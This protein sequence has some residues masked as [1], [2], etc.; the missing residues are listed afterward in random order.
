MDSDSSVDGIEVDGRL[1]RLK[2]DCCKSRRT[3]NEYDFHPCKLQKCTFSICWPCLQRWKDQSDK[4]V[5]KNFE[6]PQCHTEYDTKLI[7]EHKPLSTSIINKVNAKAKRERK[8]K[9]KMKKQRDAEMEKKR[10]VMAEKQ[11]YLRERREQSNKRKKKIKKEHD[12]GTKNNAGNKRDSRGPQHVLSKHRVILTLGNSIIL[13]SQWNEKMIHDV[14][15][16][17]GAIKPPQQTEQRIIVEFKRPFAERARRVLLYLFNL[18]IIVDDQPLRKDNKQHVAD[19]FYPSMPGGKREFLRQRDVSMNWGQFPLP[20]YG[21]LVPPGC[22][23]WV[24]QSAQRLS[25]ELFLKEM[26]RRAATKQPQPPRPQPPPQSKPPQTVQTVR[27]PPIRPTPVTNSKTSSTAH[28]PLLMPSGGVPFV[29]PHRR[30]QNKPSIP[31]VPPPQTLN[32]APL[33]S[34]AAPF[35]MSGRG[36]LSNAHNE[37]HALFSQ[38]DP[39]S[40]AMA[41]SHPFHSSH[42]HPSS[43]AV[44]H[45]PPHHHH[46]SHQHPVDSPSV[47]SLPALSSAANGAGGSV[48][49]YSNSPFNEYK[50]SP[51]D[52][53]CPPGMNLK[54]PAVSASPFGLGLGLGIGIGAG[55]SRLHPHRTM[56]STDTTST[57]TTAL[58]SASM[59]MDRMTKINSILANKE[60]RPRGPPFRIRWRSENVPDRPIAVVSD[61]DDLSAG[62]DDAVTIASETATSVT[63]KSASKLNSVQNSVLSMPSV[64]SMPSPQ[65]DGYDGDDGDYDYSDSEDDVVFM[66]PQK[67]PADQQSGNVHKARSDR[68][69]PTGLEPTGLEPPRGSSSSKIEGMTIQKM[70]DNLDDFQSHEV[71]AILANLLSKKSDLNLDH[72]RPPH[73]VPPSKHNTFSP[74]AAAAPHP[75][76]E[77]EDLDLEMISQIMNETTPPNYGEVD[78]LSAVNS[79]PVGA[80]RRSSASTAPNTVNKASAFK[81]DVFQNGH[82]RP[83]RGGVGPSTSSRRPMSLSMERHRRDM[84]LLGKANERFHLSA[85]PEV[86]RRH[87]ERSIKSMYDGKVKE[88][89]DYFYDIFAMEQGADSSHNV[90]VSLLFDG[91]SE[92]KH[93]SPSHSVRGSASNKKK[94]RSPKSAKSKKSKVAD[95]DRDFRDGP[96]AMYSAPRTVPAAHHHIVGQTAAVGTANAYSCYGSNARP[97]MSTRKVA[98][99]VGRKVKN[100]GDYED[101]ELP[102]TPSCSEEDE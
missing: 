97:Y 95:E 41:P 74:L 78:A 61:E 63:N 8:R 20:S 19:A 98:G 76:V 31:T 60:H 28:S 7:E 79:P 57:A 1:Y 62:E 52:S 15:G 36:A 46:Q 71:D 27:P 89:V 10:A 68:I 58:S 91:E 42:P 85:F 32:R 40:N 75:M 53:Q 101:E 47:D 11:K 84:E 93:S 102:H 35:A 65:I 72:D 82:R 73:P 5:T 44:H 51:P 92:S 12:K 80:V 90:V 69:E 81:P 37:P 54:R 33:L 96:S 29:P 30:I 88:L 49:S 6:C 17:I 94:K 87:F 83:P 50:A 48:S 66:P 25:K 77:D 99:F 38:H 3:E 2:C 70:L 9:L 21:N 24:N 23:R 86:Y 64:Q 14:F 34:S 16:K 100:Y 18:H 67:M 55:P 43:T 4:D 26:Q 59:S 22:R 13:K 39:V 45:P 56:T